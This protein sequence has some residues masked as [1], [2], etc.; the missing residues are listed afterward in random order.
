[1]IGFTMRT[2]VVPTFGASIIADKDYTVSAEVNT[3]LP[4]AGGGIA[5]RIY[6]LMPVPDTVIP[7]LT[8][9]AGSRTLIGTPTTPNATAVALTYTVTDVNSITTAQTFTVTVH[10]A[11]TFAESVSDQVYAIGDSVALTLPEASDGAGTL[12]YTLARTD[13]GSPTLP[14]GLSFNATAHNI[15]GSPSAGFGG[16]NG[17]SMRYTATDTNGADESLTFTMRVFGIDTATIDDQ[18]Y[19]TET[20]I[21][22]TLPE[23]SG[24]TGTLSYT[25]TPDA[26]IPAG[27]SFDPDTRTLA[28]T[29]TTTNET[30]AALTYT[31]TDANGRTD[32]RIFTVTVYSAL[33]F[34][35]ATT[36]LN[37]LYTVGQSVALTLP[38]GGA[39]RTC[40]SAPPTCTTRCWTTTAPAC[41]SPSR[42]RWSPLRTLARPPLTIR[43]TPLML[44]STRLCRQSAAALPR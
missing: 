25:L 10:S 18:N 33:T 7:G 21:N 19:Y 42:C 39:R 24:G 28:G 6:A 29:P 41:S 9:V 43:A 37:Q 44:T 26:S 12:L 36:D 30:A 8:F 16:S 11:P 2:A 4:T 35:D 23:A 15:E 14:G 22:L 13:G 31:A 3:V 32:N 17:A 27:L 38:E 5:P 20:A 34:T 1:M 40:R